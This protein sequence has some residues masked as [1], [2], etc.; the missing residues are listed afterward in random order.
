MI[1]VEINVGRIQGKDYFVPAGRTGEGVTEE[2]AL[3]L[4]LENEKHFNRM[5]GGGISVLTYT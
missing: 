4:S 5:R 1:N 2:I 3:D